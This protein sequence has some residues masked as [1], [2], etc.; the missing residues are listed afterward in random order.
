MQQKGIQSPVE[1]IKINLLER[2]KIDSTRSHSPLLQASDAVAIDN[3]NLT[4]EEQ[5]EMIVAL[6]NCRINSNH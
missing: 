1:T 6:A 3:S 5:M 4:I 2:D